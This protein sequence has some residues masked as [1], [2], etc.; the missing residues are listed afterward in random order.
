MNA[1]VIVRLSK[2]ITII[3]QVFNELKVREPTG[4]DL[5]EAGD[6][7]SGYGF[8]ARIAA[9]CA[10][11]PVEA[12]ERLAARDALALTGVISDFLAA[13]S[14]EGSETLTSKPP[15]GGETPSSS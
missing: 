9:P 8:L 13:P 11:I 1:P 5:M 12:F 14:P 6:T 7:T 15:A 10:N 3:D 2:P 4:R